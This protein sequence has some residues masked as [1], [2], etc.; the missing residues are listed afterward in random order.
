LFLASGSEK[1]LQVSSINLEVKQH[2][3]SQYGIIVDINRDQNPTC[4]VNPP[5]TEISLMMSIDLYTA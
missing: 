4:I 1:S 5:V 2:T 3:L